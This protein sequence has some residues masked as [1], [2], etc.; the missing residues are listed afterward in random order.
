MEKSPRTIKLPKIQ[1]LKSQYPRSPAFLA[2]QQ[3]RHRP[4]SP[5]TLPMIPIPIPSPSTTA[6]TTT[7]TCTQN[8]IAIQSL[9]QA[10]A[11]PA[12]EG[13]Y[14]PCI[15]GWWRRAR[16]SSP[17]TVAVSMM[18]PVWEGRRN[19]RCY[20]A[21]PKTVQDVFGGTQGYRG[22]VREVEWLGAD[23]VAQ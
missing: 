17:V 10:T 13:A 5:R 22:A 14:E 15:H 18:R 9:D 7:R 2:L 20:R 1:T 11:P 3:I 23:P 21:D 16:S 19:D 6:T 4:P 8:D 12:P